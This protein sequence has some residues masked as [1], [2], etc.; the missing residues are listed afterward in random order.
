MPEPA[1]LNDRYIRTDAV[2]A[3]IRTVLRRLL[4]ASA[5]IAVLSVLVGLL[6]AGL[7]GVWAGLLAAGISLVF[8]ATTVLGLHL[9][10]GRGPELL[11]IVL[12]GGWL[13]KMALLAVALLWLRDQDFYHR[14]VFLGT[15]FV[16]VIAAVLVELI[17]IASSKVPYVTPQTQVTP[18]PGDGPEG[19]SP[20]RGEADQ[21]SQ[22]RHDPRA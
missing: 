2:L 8:T 22:E 1:F 5:A 3:L 19:D 18:E 7:P 16:A 11:Q 20:D 13:V 21:P 4:L 10:A 15:L 12:L 14:G 17:T 9:V 6:V